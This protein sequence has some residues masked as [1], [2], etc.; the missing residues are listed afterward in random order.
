[1]KHVP[2]QLSSELV[3][4]HLNQIESEP[5]ST[6]RLRRPDEVHDAHL[7]RHDAERTRHV[8]LEVRQECRISRRNWI[9]ELDPKPQRPFGARQRRWCRWRKRW[10]P[11]RRRCRRKQRHR[12]TRRRLCRRRRWRTRVAEVERLHREAEAARRRV[13]LVGEAA[14]HRRELRRVH[15]AERGGRPDWLDARV[16]RARRECHV[17]RLARSREVRPRRQEAAL[18]QRVGRNCRCG[19]TIERHQLVHHGVVGVGPAVNVVERDVQLPERRHLHGRARSH[20]SERE[21]GAARRHR[22]ACS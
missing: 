2:A 14:Q 17:Q 4:E 6:W 3:A 1:M 9:R 15:D 20:Q 11:L 5:P 19:R 16:L 18:Q 12:P 21:L 8:L 10:R 13:R 22:A 7:R